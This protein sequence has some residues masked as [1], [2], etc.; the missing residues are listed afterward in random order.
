MTSRDVRK[1]F[2]DFYRKRNHRVVKSA[3]LLPSDDPTLLFT[4]AGMV[5]FKKMYTTPSP[6]YRRAASIQ[7]CLRATDLEDVGRT[8]RHCT[9][10]EMLGHFSFGDYFKKEAIVW[11][12]D[13]F[14]N[15]YEIAEEKMQVSVFT[16]D[17][18]AFSIWRDEVGLPEEKIHRLGAEDNFW[19]PAGDTGP[20][21]PSSEVYYDL[22][23][24]LGCGLP[25]CAPGCDC[26]RWAEIGNFVFPQFDRQPDGSDAPLRNR[27]IDTGIGLE[28][29]TMV[30]QGKASIFETDL[31]SPLIHQ[32]EELTG[33]SYQEAQVPMNIVADHVRALTFAL[34]EGIM[35][36]NEGR[37]YVLRRILRRAALQGYLMGLREAFLAPLAETVVEIMGDDYPEVGEALPRVS[38][39]LRGEE[40]RF[41][42][43]V[44]AGVHRFDRLAERTKSSGSTAISGADAFL[45][46]DTFGFPLDLVQDMASREGLSVDQE[47]FQEHMERQKERSRRTATFY[48]QDSEDALRWQVFQEGDGNRFVGYETLESE[49]KVLRVTA[50]PDSPDEYWVVLEE[51][52]FYA[53]A[54]GQVGDTGVLE[55]NGL[56]AKVVDTQKF[57]DEIRHRVRLHSGSWGPS[58]VTAKVNA[59]LRLSTVRNHTATHLLH[60]ALRQVLGTHVT[61]AGSL[62]APDRLRFDFTHY[63]SLRGE[64]IEEIERIVNERILENT[65]VRVRWSDYEEAIKEGVMA[66]FGEKYDE[67]VRRVEVGEFSR[68][69]CG[70][71]HV[72]ATGDIGHFMILEESAISA[73]VRRIE[74]A[75]GERAFRK[76]REMQNVLEDLRRDLKVPVEK[77]PER[78]AQLQQEITRLRKEVREALEKGPGGGLDDLLGQAENVG[79]RRFVVARMEAPSVGVLRKQGDKIADS[80]GSGVALL[81]AQVGKKQSLLAVV[82]ADL[83]SAGVSADA[84]VRDVAAVTGG[85]GGGNPRMALAGV[86]D[87]SKLDEALVKAREMLRKELES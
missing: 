21:G 74:A 57:H 28:R 71:T 23:E 79:S 37:G 47:G 60:A 5:P 18:E 38:M 49:T 87:S 63:G 61:Q 4:S 58:P 77:L 84:I 65:T 45:L 36:S 6:E 1:I 64:E 14:R 43:T 33:K 29:V 15:H 11:N 30:V 83:A 42:E 67:N 68:E 70:G 13:L 50:V 17:D 44:D 82:T 27:G 25:Q 72:R 41:E 7:K 3:P 80:L 24:G 31:F 66:L 9:F 19:G 39:A 35:P 69:L 12:W 2:L 34:T 73:G 75:T 55:G 52:P 59:A 81:A 56:E 46:Y 85:R 53:E 86:G 8:P 20:C 54:G 32:L 48:S 40:E 16:D 22:G 26:D 78:V 76:R 51:T 62:V 10:F